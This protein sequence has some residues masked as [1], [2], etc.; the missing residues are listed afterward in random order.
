[1]ISVLDFFLPET[2]DIFAAETQAVEREDRSETGVV[3]DK[4]GMTCG[5]SIVVHHLSVSCMSVF[6]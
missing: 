4:G 1:M 6:Q 3:S 2:Q 5:S